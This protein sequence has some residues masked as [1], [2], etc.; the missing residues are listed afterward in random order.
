MLNSLI[1]LPVWFLETWGGGVRGSEWEPGAW[2]LDPACLPLG[3]TGG[4]RLETGGPPAWA[5]S[6]PSS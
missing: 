3:G 4:V 2:P 1:L 6:W 5:Q